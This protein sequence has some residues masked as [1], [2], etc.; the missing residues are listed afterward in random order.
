MAEIYVKIYRIVSQILQLKTQDLYNNNV[1]LICTCIIIPLLC[2]RKVKFGE[3]SISIK[4]P[5]LGKRTL[6]SLKNST[7]WEDDSR[8]PLLDWLRWYYV[9]KWSSLY[10]D[11]VLMHWKSSRPE[12]ACFFLNTFFIQEMDWIWSVGN[13]SVKFLYVLCYKLKYLCIYF[14]LMISV[15][16]TRTLIW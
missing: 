1:M 14:C 6:R 2:Y 11:I 16:R 7:Y 10:I 5:N 13:K 3:K 8:E 12:D 9:K 15:W 4:W